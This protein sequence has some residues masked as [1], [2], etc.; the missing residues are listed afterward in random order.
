M[1]DRVVSETR[2]AIDRVDRDL[3]GAVNRRLELVQQLHEHKVAS[4]IALRD[5]G[6]EEAMIASLEA[7]NG[8]PLSARGVAELFRYL[9]DLTRRELHGA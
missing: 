3:L 7:A 4:G 2:E 9:L 6:R 8:G 5:P 1:S